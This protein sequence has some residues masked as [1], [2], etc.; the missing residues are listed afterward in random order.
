M[1]CYF[2]DTATKSEAD[3]DRDGDPEGNE[4][5]EALRPA[6]RPLREEDYRVEERPAGGEALGAELGEAKWLLVGT[7]VE[8]VGGD[9]GAPRPNPAL[10][11]VLGRR[12]N[13][14][15]LDRLDRSLLWVLFH[16][17]FTSIC[18]FAFYMHRRLKESCCRKTNQPG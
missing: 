17:L 15:Y 12:S 2:S 1:V 18:Y 11:H 8:P 5:G 3:G 6:D 4:L 14:F 10:L 7:A 13:A 9:G 16:F